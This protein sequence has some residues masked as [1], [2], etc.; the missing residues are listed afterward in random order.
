MLID[1]HCHFDFGAFDNN[2]EQCWR[3]CRQVGVEKL[4]VPGVNPD[5][6]A[7]SFA[8]AESLP[9]VYMAAG[10][11][12]WWVAQWGQGKHPDDLKNALQ[13]WLARP[14]CVAVGECGLDGYLDTP[15]EQQLPWFEQQLQLAC[16]ANLPVIIHVLKAH[17]LVM[18]LLG[19]YRLPRGGV[20]HAFTGSAELGRQYWKLGFSLG[21]GGTIT[22]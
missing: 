1:S 15:V 6:M 20:I 2:R 14:R 12:P 9:G 21:I 3:D 5:T 7:E 22:Y 11:H 19:K 18:E 4:V 8:M 10:L 13:P 16:D 17:N